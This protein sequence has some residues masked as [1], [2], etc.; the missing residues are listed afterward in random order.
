MGT[1]YSRWRMTVA[2]TTDHPWNSPEQYDDTDQNDQ[3]GGKEGEDKLIRMLKVVGS[4][5]QR[6]THKKKEDG[7]Y[8]AGSGYGPPDQR[9]YH[10]ILPVASRLSVAA[11]WS[12]RC[13]RIK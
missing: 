8:R 9:P 6:D 13:G 7:Q 10:I 11:V 4:P 1:I 2:Q 5:A 3:V 12:C